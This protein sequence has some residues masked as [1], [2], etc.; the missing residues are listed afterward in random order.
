M[1]VIHPESI[2][3][4]ALL[5]VLSS[6]T[7]TSILLCHFNRRAPRRSYPAPLSTT[8]PWTY[9][10]PLSPLPCVDAPGSAVVDYVNTPDSSY[11]ITPSSFSS[12]GPSP[13]L[14]EP[15]NLQAWSRPSEASSPSSGPSSPVRASTEVSPSLL[16]SVGPHPRPL[17][18]S[19]LADQ[20]AL[21]SPRSLRQNVVYHYPDLVDG[22]VRGSPAGPP[23][24]YPAHGMKQLELTSS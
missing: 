14:P 16:G 17:T 1:P 19:D 7:T 15:L 5:H 18:C 9:W 4:R 11:S 10:H 24:P 21:I 8:S 23:S 3:K 22:H 12:P 20:D 13:S 2:G 6:P